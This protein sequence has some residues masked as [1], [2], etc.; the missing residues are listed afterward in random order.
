[1]RRR[2]RK[3]KPRCLERN[4]RKNRE[5]ERESKTKAGRK[6]WRGGEEGVGREKDRAE[7]PHSAC[8]RSLG[9]RDST[10]RRE[11]AGTGR[12][13]GCWKNRKGP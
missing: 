11:R 3:E 6:E 12:E 5:K 8:I 9:P 2:K 7:P 1:V 4:R 13:P 10:G